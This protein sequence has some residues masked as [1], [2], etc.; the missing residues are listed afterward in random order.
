MKAKARRARVRNQIGA[1]GNQVY[2]S[3]PFFIENTEFVSAF[4]GLGQFKDILAQHRLAVKAYGQHA[5]SWPPCPNFI[6]ETKR[7]RAGEIKGKVE[8]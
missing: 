5:H 3:G 1:S 8:R 6:H 7:S 2:F 4:H